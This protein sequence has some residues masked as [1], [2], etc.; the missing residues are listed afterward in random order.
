M[1]AAKCKYHSLADMN[2]AY[3]QMRVLPEHVNRT[4][5]AMPD[6]NMDSKVMQI[7]DCK[8]IQTTVTYGIVWLVNA[9]VQCP[10][11]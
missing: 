5:M 2:V 8:N 7:S 10:T 9:H 1:Q 6:G 4:M 3:E 11:M